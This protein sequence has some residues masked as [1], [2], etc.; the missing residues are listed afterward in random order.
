MRD[1]NDDGTRLVAELAQRHGFSQDAVEH[2]LRAIAAGQGTQAQFRH[3]EFG[4]MGQ[5]SYGGMTMIGDMFN[6]GLKT[7]VNALCA[8]LSSSLA[9]DS[10]FKPTSQTSGQTGASF[11]LQSGHMSSGNADWPAELG[12][13][14]SQGAQNDMRYAY[15]PQTRRLGIAH[16]GS[17]MIYDTGEHQIYG[18]GQA[19]SGWQ[20]LT[21]NS[22]LG[23]VH[24]TDLKVVPMLDLDTL[25]RPDAVSA[26]DRPAS[27]APAP[28]KTAPAKSDEITAS[29]VDTSDEQIFSKIE[30]LADLRDRGI[31]S[32]AEFTDKKTELLSRL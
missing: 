5:W 31:L 15:F 30:R 28:A 2:M 25:E 11:Q 7:R 1:L 12:A 3:P 14:T 18:F 29:A 26:A 19:Q 27:P 17:M 21:F 13:P 24:V 9:Q 6:N 4:G 8:E 10:I 16:G 20:S 32:E 23:Q 22:Q